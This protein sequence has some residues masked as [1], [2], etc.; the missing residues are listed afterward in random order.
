LYYNKPLGRSFW[1]RFILL[2]Q[3]SDSGAMFW[4]KRF[5]TRLGVTGVSFFS[6]FLEFLSRNYCCLSDP[7]KKKD[8]CCKAS[9]RRLKQS[10]EGASWTI[11]LSIIYLN[12]CGRNKNDA[13]NHWATLPTMYSIW[14]LNQGFS[15]QV[16]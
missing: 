12:H 4:T 6:E 5:R 7:T 14:I 16:Y 2:S 15:A 8:K 1:L 10:D 3:E 11:D 9:Y 13:R